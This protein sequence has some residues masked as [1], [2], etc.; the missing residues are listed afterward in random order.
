M[1]HATQVVAPGRIGDWQLGH[2]VAVLMLVEPI[3][4]RSRMPQHA[5]AGRFDRPG[6]AV[7]LKSREI[8]ATIDYRRCYIVWRLS[9][10]DSK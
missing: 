2:V 8:D 9:C 1:P 4:T 3:V 6:E 10:G 5:N 7:I